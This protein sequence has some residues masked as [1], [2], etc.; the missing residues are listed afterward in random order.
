[1]RK[2]MW[3]KNSGNLTFLYLFILFLNLYTYTYII[4][5]HK[6]RTLDFQNIKCSL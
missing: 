2:D 6:F 5:W 3:Q 1:M 4:I